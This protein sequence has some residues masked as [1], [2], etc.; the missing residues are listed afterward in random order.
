V[1]GND[2]TGADVVAVAPAAA[3]PQ[4]VAAQSPAPAGFLRV[5]AG[6]RQ[7]LVDDSQQGGGV[8]TEIL[9]SGLQSDGASGVQLTWSS[10]RSADLA[11]LNEGKTYDV[12]LAW[13]ASD[14][15]AVSDLSEQSAML[16]DQFL[17][18][19]PILQ[20]LTVLFA[21]SDSGFEF[22]EDGEIAGKSLCLP[23][24]AEEA[25]L[26]RGGRGWLK[27]QLVTVVRAPTL[28]ACFKLVAARDAD[29]VM[30]SEIEGRTVLAASGLG[31]E[32]EMLERPIATESLSAVV[33]RNHPQAE[34]IVSRLNSAL[35][36]VKSN[37]AYYSLVDK[38]LV[39][40]WGN[41]SATP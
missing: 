20:V 24:G 2:I 25:E 35:A 34:Q 5:V 14:C 3:V 29:A 36:R 19:E 39:A 40:L 26:N 30:A 12:G 10:D 32:I 1:S 38:H 16:C 28:E 11:G 8:V 6:R 7:P 41:A 22:N 21:K 4:P 31:G 37:G 13:P 15:D 17:F 33:A 9:T 27:Q 18:T 23:A